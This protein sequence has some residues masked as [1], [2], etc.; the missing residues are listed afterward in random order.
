[1]QSIYCTEIKK[2]EVNVVY[3]VQD[4]RFW[5]LFS[6]KST[7]LPFSRCME[8]KC[9]IVRFL[10]VFSVI[11]ATTKSKFNKIKN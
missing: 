1:L 2:E 4:S 3:G 11:I 5:K 9:V 7:R 6:I 8:L 10:S